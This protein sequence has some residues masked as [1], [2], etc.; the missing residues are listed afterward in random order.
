MKAQRLRAY[1]KYIYKA[2]LIELVVFSILCYFD[3][4]FRAYL[5]L[6][7][8]SL[9]GGYFKFETK[10]AE[11]KK[12]KDKGLTEEDVYNIQF[13]KKWEETRE[14]GIWRYCI[15]DGGIIF[16]AYLWIIVSALLIATSIIK[17]QSLVDDPGNMFGFIGYSYRTGAVIGVIIYRIL[18]PYQERRF[19]RLTDPLRISHS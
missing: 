17:F 11:I 18:W 14:K 9:I 6:F 16:G 5:I 4:R 10:Q 19:I 15:I 2:L 7:V 1:F 12:L 8:F 3:K 13:V